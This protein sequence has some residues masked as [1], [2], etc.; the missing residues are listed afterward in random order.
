M[1]QLLKLKLNRHDLL[2]LLN[3]ELAAY[4]QCAQC[5][6]AGIDPL[7]EAAWTAHLEDEGQVSLAQYAL[8][9]QVV[10]QT[11]QVFDLS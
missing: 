1:G 11:R 10:E 4:E 3:W 6:F 8:A 7:P 9:R 2:Q 5:H